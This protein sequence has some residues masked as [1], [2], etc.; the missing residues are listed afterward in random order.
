M[1]VPVEDFRAAGLDEQFA[2]VERAVEAH[3]EGSLSNVAVVAEPFAGRGALLDYGEEL[4]E[5]ETV[6]RRGFEAPMTDALPEFQDADAYVLDDCHYLFQRTI[7]GFEAVEAFVDRMAR[8]DALFLTAWNRYA[9]SY[10]EAV[11][12]IER[13][14]PRVVQVPDF[15]ADQLADVIGSV[16]GPDL[17]EYVE[18]GSEGHIKSVEWTRYPIDLPGGRSVGLPVLKPNPEYVKAWASRETEK[19]TEA[20]VLEKIRRASGGNLGVA[21]DLWARSVT[22]GEIATGDVRA[23]DPTFEMDEGGALLLWM[24]VSMERVPRA[25]LEE[26]LTDVPVDS[27]VQHLVERG[28]VDLDGEAVVLTPQGFRPAV[29]ELRRRRLLW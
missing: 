15:D 20:V 28:V 23:P 18:R 21:A 7:G 3:R 1:S 19:S 14:F 22:D 17:P 25:T 5:E 16:F 24:V 11:R 26:T 2:A 8:S 12:E 29:A 27:V 6:V 13:V 4:L 9:F 10:L